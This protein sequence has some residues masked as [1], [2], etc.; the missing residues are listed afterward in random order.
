MYP[1]TGKSTFRL[2]LS[3]LDPPRCFRI[4]RNTDTGYTDPRA[5]E[6]RLRHGVAGA[7]LFQVCTFPWLRRLLHTHLF[8]PAVPTTHWPHLVLL[9]RC[10]LVMRQWLGTD[11]GLLSPKYAVAW[12]GGGGTRRDWVLYQPSTCPEPHSLTAAAPSSPCGCVL[13]TY[14]SNMLTIY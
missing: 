7:S 12:G 1:V 14:R 3:F 9:F 5:R 11:W 13:G 6:P 4:A 10:L 8:K 2:Q